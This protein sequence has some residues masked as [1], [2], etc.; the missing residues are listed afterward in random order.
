[1]S[2]HDLQ[3]ENLDRIGRGLLEATRVKSDELEKIIHAPHLF[4]SVKARIKAE[5]KPRRKAKAFFFVWNLQTAS[6]SFAI[7]IV[8]LAVAAVLISRAPQRLHVVEAIKTPAIE[9]P[10]PEVGNSSPVTEITKTKATPI[11]NPAVAEKVDFKAETPNLSNRAHKQNSPK[12]A[13]SEKKQVKDVFYPLA[14]GG[15]WE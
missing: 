4:D 15:N 8:V 5:Q 1:M 7:L 3:K 2:K 10:V 14:F 9:A 11:K 13:Q 6:A 12:Q